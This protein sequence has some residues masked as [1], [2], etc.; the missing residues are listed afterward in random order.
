MLIENVA[1]PIFEK[2]TLLVVVAL[3]LLIGPVEPPVAVYVPT[4][5][6]K[7]LVPNV[8][9]SVLVFVRPPSVIMM[10]VALDIP[11]TTALKLTT[12]LPDV[13]VCPLTLDANEVDTPLA[14][15]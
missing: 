12:N 15:T 14:L 13:S 8:A 1:L 4:A 7:T 2:L 6:A 5:E 11:E 9:L 10:L 3:P